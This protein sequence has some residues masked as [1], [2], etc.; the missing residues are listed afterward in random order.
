L[1]R[2]ETDREGGFAG[3]HKAL[4]FRRSFDSAFI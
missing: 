2:K 3:E 4:V 1:E